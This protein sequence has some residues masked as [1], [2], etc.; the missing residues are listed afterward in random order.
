MTKNEQRQQQRYESIQLLSYVCIDE[1]GKE[2]KQGMGR[3]LNINDIGLKLETHEPI[4]TQYIVLLAVGLEDEVVDVKG[5]VIYCNRNEMARF[6]SGVE[7]YDLDPGSREIITR[8]VREFNKQ[9]S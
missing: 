8:F 2:W 3:T 1:E 5:R 7:F 6:E 9:Y 4:E